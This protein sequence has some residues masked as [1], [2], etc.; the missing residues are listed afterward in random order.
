MAYGEGAYG[1]G[2]YGEG[3]GAGAG[4]TISGGHYVET[5]SLH[6]GT[7]KAGAA[8][9]G[10]HLAE[11][12]TLHPGSVQSGLLIAGGHYTETASLH[13]G[14]IQI[15]VPGHHYT[16]TP[17]LH[18]GTTTQ[19][20]GLQV[21]GNHYAEVVDLHPGSASLGYGTTRR[22]RAGGRRR[23]GL[24]TATWTPA[25]TAVPVPFTYG[26]AV[27]L[28]QAFT[29]PVM[30]GTQPTY[31]VTTASLP[32]HRDR[33]VVG[34]KDITFFRN[35]PTPTPEYQLVEP[36]TYGPATL[37]LPQI[38]AAFETPG[39]GDLSWLKPGKTVLVQRVDVDTNTVVATDYRGIVIAFNT[40]GRSLSVEIGGEAS[41]RA[42]LRDM[43]L[44]IFRAVQ[45]AGRWAWHAIHALGLRFTP[46]LGPDTG[47]DLARFGGTGHLDYIRELCAKAQDR[48]GTQWTINRTENA[49]Y[50]F[51][52]K[53]T[54][55][56][57]GTVYL[58][59]ARCVAD[60]RRDLAE[61]PNVVYATGV[62]PDGHRFNGGVFPGLVQ[63]ERA[64]YPFHDGRTFGLG[65]QDADT[66]TGDGITT[67]IGRMRVC[68]LV[69]A[70]DSP[71]G[72]DRDI[73]RAV[74]VLQDKAGLSETGVMNHATWNALYDLGVTGPS[75]RWSHIAPYAQK[76]YTRPFNVSGSG[77]IMGRNPNFDPSRLRVDRT[78]D[79]GAGVK[80]RQAH[81][82]SRREIDQSED[83]WVGTITLHTGAVVAGD[84]TPG[85]PITS[86]LRARDITT[87]MNLTLPLF[88]GGITVHVSAVSVSDT[89]TLTVDTRARDAMEVWE[90]IARNRESRRDPARQWERQ[91]RASG[92]IKDSIDGWWKQ[93]GLVGSRIPLHGGRWNVFYVIAG[94]AG[95]VQKL[96]LETNPNAEYAVAIFG[97]EINA[98]TLDNTVGNPLTDAGKGK[99]TDEQIRARLDD[100]HLLL[101]AAGDKD[102]PCGYGKKH[103]SESGAPLNGKFEDAAGFSYYTQNLPVL[104]VAIYPDRNTSIP[105]GRIMWEQLEAG[106]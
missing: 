2:V 71:G 99:W 23:S 55:T 100:K 62:A 67:M 9:A 36:L 50:R 8:V 28:A 77:T 7:S 96:A 72:F 54:T 85:A 42:A 106:A 51:Q 56:V 19:V 76:S 98:K 24:G 29:T 73:V 94:Q 14:T 92:Q 58:D 64:P 66:D 41:G 59:D 10:G 39:V 40:S 21:L 88:A 34:G 1:A 37:D 103:K 63:G 93:G 83:N 4:V 18:S 30:V 22:T 33:I 47:I 78:V 32:R 48:D 70:E 91:H 15:F 69:G 95:T 87:G 97:D 46:R 45:D 31:T 49:G 52:R 84:H 20:T 90:I 80:E 68:R 75:L 81:E 61:E 102:D 101:Y 43:P 38:A 3:A 105:A 53:D 13:A 35:V 25:V 82:W 12:V 17:T 6:A 79:F 26:Q 104:W 16:E 27:D 44:P 65:T 60:L 74:K 5:A 86:I 11:V 89:V 57:D